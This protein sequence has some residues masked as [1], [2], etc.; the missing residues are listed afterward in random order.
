[1]PSAT[2]NTLYLTGATAYHKLLSFFYF[3]LLARFLGVD[4][5][6]KYT[7]ALAFVFMFSI[8]VDFE[9]SRVLTREIARDRAKTK[10]YLSNIFGFKL[11]TGLIIFFLIFLLI[12]FLGYPKLTKVF[13]YFASLIMLLDSFS[14]T[15]Y[16]TFRGYLNLKFEALGII[17][18]KTASFIIGLI[19]ILL[20][21]PAVLI[22]LPLLAG[23]LL[24]FINALFFLKKETGFLPSFSLNKSVIK[25]L[26]IIAWP[27]F[28]AGIFSQLFGTVDTVLLSFLD[29]DRAVGLYNSA[30]KIVVSLGI[31]IG[32]SLSGVV[33]PEF[34]YYFVR[35]KQRL[36]LIFT[37]SIF[38]L[39]IIA[40]PLVFGALL[41]AQ[42]IISFIYGVD[43][44][45]AEGTL[46]VLSFCLPFMFLD[47]SL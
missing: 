15:I 14:L 31:L 27:F 47:Y 24:Y 12:N 3:I 35:D 36:S 40:L 18:N 23:S 29:G 16:Q 22:I 2:K 13:V 19:F 34:S 39:L 4:N 6:G 8:F 17:L 20:K 7:F 41:L 28:I 33:Y 38:Y 44:Q 26:L 25:P 5:F 37:R 21:L 46:R 42:P 32:G 9:L 30:Q 11:F 1:M 45:Q 10:N 43:Y